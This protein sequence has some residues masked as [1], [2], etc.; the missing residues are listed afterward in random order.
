MMSIEQLADNLNTARQHAEWT[1]EV[2][3][4]LEEE[5]DYHRGEALRAEAELVGAY[6]E[7]DA[8]NRRVRELESELIAA[9]GEAS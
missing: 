6:P 8:A 5:R 7:Q 1:A 9:T 3:K 2:V 4:S